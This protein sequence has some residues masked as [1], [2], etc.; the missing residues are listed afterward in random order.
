MALTWPPEQGSAG[1]DVRTVQYPVTAQDHPTEADG[2]FGPLTK[3]AMQ[4]FQSSRGLRAN[5]IV[6]PHSWPRH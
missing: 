2:D 1:E 6:G 4:A 3:A 5:E